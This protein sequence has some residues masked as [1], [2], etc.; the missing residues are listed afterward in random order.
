MKECTLEEIIIS[1]TVTAI[2]K[3]ILEYCRSL[4]K[5]IIDKNNPVYNSGDNND[6]IIE[7]KTGNVIFKIN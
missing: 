2:D 4:K 6:S 1:D 7:T 3:S 5:I